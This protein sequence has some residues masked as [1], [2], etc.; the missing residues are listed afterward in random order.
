VTTLASLLSFELR[1]ED[2]VVCLYASLDDDV[3]EETANVVARGIAERRIGVNPR[4]LA[5]WVQQLAVTDGTQPSPSDQL[6][7]VAGLLQ[8]VGVPAAPDPP[9]HLY[10][11]VAE[12]IWLEVIA[13][14]DLGLGPPVRVDGH[15]YSVTDPGGD[16]LT[17]HATENGNFC[18]R[19][20]ESKYHG[21]VDPIRE[22]VQVACRQ[23]QNRAVSYL[24]RFALIAQRL[25]DCLELA[26]FYARLPEMWVDKDPAAGASVAI[27]TSELQGDCFGG[28]PGYFALGADRHQGELNAVGNFPRFAERVRE[29]LWRGCGWS[30]L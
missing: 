7:L 29:I 20:W 22:T 15:D 12:E 30:A 25:T 27:G 1:D 14:Q 18:F 8:N 6:L 17:V 16:G 19:L 11:L 10:G 23:L 9:S 4:L 24:S 13:E 21:T 26:K 28:I 5:V 3:F 2:G